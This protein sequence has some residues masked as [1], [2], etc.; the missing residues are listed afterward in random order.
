MRNIIIYKR[1]FYEFYENLNLQVREKIDFVLY[2]VRSTAR[3]PSKF[4]K[5]LENTDGLYEIRVEYSGNIYRI[6]CCFDEGNL[7]VLLNGYQKKSQK[8]PK[9][10]LEKALKIK[11]EY[12][13]NKI[14]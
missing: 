11:A 4:F 6:F 14:I 1:Y 12:F 10:D 2:L 5:H 8:S 7:I 13:N 3:I 9:M